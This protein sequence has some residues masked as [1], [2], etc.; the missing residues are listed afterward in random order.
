MNTIKIIMMSF[1]MASLYAAEQ[2]LD[3]EE[4]CESV[5]RRMGKRTQMSYVVR[6]SGKSDALV[7][8]R[9]NS[10]NIAVIVTQSEQRQRHMYVDMSEGLS[11]IDYLAQLKRIRALKSHD[12]NNVLCFVCIMCVESLQSSQLGIEPEGW[13]EGIKS[14]ISLSPS[15]SSKIIKYSDMTVPGRGDDGS[16]DGVFKMSAHCLDITCISERQE[17]G[18]IIQ[19]H[20]VSF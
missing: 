10:K 11:H 13:I 5:S 17:K 15:A 20:K 14:I 19:K 18:S 12:K 16:E 8:E 4:E 2:N 1:L 7:I 3:F 9:F 6:E